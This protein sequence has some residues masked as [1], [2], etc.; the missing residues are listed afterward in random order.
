MTNARGGE[1][2]NQKRQRK[3]GSM[4][5]YLDLASHA[6]DECLIA[7][8]KPANGG[9]VRVR[10]GS[11]K[12]RGI[13]IIVCEQYHGPRPMGME[14]R[15]LCGRAAC[16][17]PNHLRWGTSAENGQDKAL[18]GSSKG[19]RNGRAKL[20]EDDVRAIRASTLSPRQLMKEYGLSK[21][22]VYNVLNG[23]NWQHIDWSAV[24]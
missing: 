19:T 20:T 11:G 21:S 4:H 6:G 1:Q 23:T 24:H 13:H 17:N 16:Y 5:R 22:Q 12:R 10:E 14:V 2:A 3:Q 18:H 7:E 8:G 15:H 9:Y